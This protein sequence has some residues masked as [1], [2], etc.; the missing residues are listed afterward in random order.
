MAISTMERA[1]RVGILQA[2]YGGAGAFVGLVLL[3]GWM[4]GAPVRFENGD[5]LPVGAMLGLVGLGAL[6]IAAGLA[7]RSDPRR[8]RSPLWIV[9][10]LA[11]MNVPV[12]TCLSL[13][14]IYSLRQTRRRGQS[15]QRRSAPAT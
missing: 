4:S 9:S 11:L 2:L 6:H 15:A 12:G 3:G 1:R 8:N 14:S 10:L 5:A 13:Y 7:Y